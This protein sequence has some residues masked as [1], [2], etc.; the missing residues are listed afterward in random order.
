MKEFNKE[1]EL[2]KLKLRNNKSKYIKYTSIILSCVILLV[3]IIYF[4]FA[5]F[6]SNKSYTLIEGR[7][8]D[9]TSGDITLSYVVDGNK[10]DT[11]PGKNDGYIIKNVNCTNATGEWDSNNWWLIVKDINGKAK[12]NL[13]F[14]EAQYNNVTKWLATA[15]INKS[16]T[17]LSEVFNDTDTL[18]TLTN[19]NASCDYLKNS[20]DWISDVTTNEN[21]MTYIGNNDYCADD[22]YF[23][24]NWDN[25]I[26]ESTYWDK[27]LQ[28][29]VPVMTSDTTPSGEVLKSSISGTVWKIF[30][31][32]TSVSSYGYVGSGSTSGGPMFM[33]F[34]FNVPVSIKKVGYYNA[35][36]SSITT[37]WVNMQSSLTFKVQAS[38]DKF[39]S[40]IHD[41]SDTISN[42]SASTWNYYLLNN[43]NLYDD[44]RIYS[45]IGNAKSSTTD[46]RN[47]MWVVH[48]LQFYGRE[49]N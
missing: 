23:D 33:G 48:E 22:L 47:L 19:N 34:H 17:T 27:V 3:G 39:V 1:R 42:I 40:D 4:T 15:S 12:C 26:V 32:S 46:G 13:E 11:P 30:D 20:T 49:A 24:D 44:Y 38:N 43:E 45:E 14:E 36:A 16:Y 35:L 6:E 7:I 21:A 2:T 37:S 28:P 25:A 8:G 29:L 5:K 9:Y 41:I 31:N 18:N 10:Q